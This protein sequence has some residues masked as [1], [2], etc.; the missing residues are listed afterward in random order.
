MPSLGKP[1]ARLKMSDKQKTGEVA[2]P[3]G[4]FRN[5]LKGENP[6]SDDSL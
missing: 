3:F 5:D 6:V 1:A 4:P 2:L